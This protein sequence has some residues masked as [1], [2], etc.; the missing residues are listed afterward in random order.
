MTTALGSSRAAISKIAMLA[1]LA[2]TGIVSPAHAQTTATVSV[3]AGSSLNTLQPQSIGVNT[4]VWDGNLLDSAVPGLLS[5][6]GIG[7]MRFP[8][9]STSDTYNWQ[10]DSIV[11]GQG[12]Y[13]NPSNTFDAF[14]G[15]AKAAGA[16][17][18]ITVNYGSNTAGNGGGTPAAAAAWVQYANVTKGYG[19]Q[20]WEIGNEVYGNGE[21]GSTW[22]TDLH[23][24]HDP[25]TYGENVAQFAS[26]MKAVDSNIKVGVVLTAPGQWPDGVAP[27][28][29]TNVLAQCGSSIDFVVVHWYPQGPGSESDSYLLTTP[30]TISGMVSSLKSLIDEYC[31]ANASK[32]QILVTETNSVSYDPGK[33]ILSTV[34][35]LFIADNMMSWLENGVTNVDVWDLH[36]GSNS[37]NISSSL[38]GT[39]TYGDY[40]ILSN[41]SSGEPAADTP[42]ATYY[43]MQMLSRLGKSGDTMVSSTSSNSLL[44]VHAVKQANGDLALLLINKDPSNTDTAT[45]SVAGFKPG[46][47]ATEYVYGKSSSAILSNPLSVSGSTFTVSSLPYSLTTVVLTPSTGAAPAPNFSLSSSVSSLAMSQSGSGTSTITVTPSSGFTGSVSLSA[48]GLPSG[49]TALFSPSSTTGTSTLTLKA[50]STAAT[51]AATITVTGTSGS[52]THTATFS[53]QVNAS[54]TTSSPNFTLTSSLS[55]ATLSAGQTAT[56]TITLTPSGGFNGSVSLAQSGCPTGVIAWFN[57]NSITGSTT[58]NIEANSTAKAGTATIT[59]TGTSGSITHTATIAVTIGGS[60][61]TPAPS[62]TLSAGSSSASVTQGAS[63]TSSITVTPSNGFTSSV[64]LSASGLPSGVTA[65]FSPSST[66]GSSTLTLTASSSAAVGTSTVTITGTSESTSHTTT[67]SLQVNAAKT[68]T[69]NAP[70][71]TANFT[72]SSNVSRVSLSAGQTSTPTITVTPSGGFTGSVSLSQSGCPTGVIA[73]FNSNSTTGSTTFNIQVNSTAKPGTA[74]ITVTGT[75]GSIT[76][77]VTIPVTIG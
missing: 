71:G 50:S 28:W 54:A 17:P 6:A 56:P 12:G 59:V 14:M 2:M 26:A 65:S 25:T 38:F 49:V 20:Y 16:A 27:D 68:N 58:F 62:F 76:H 32:V 47:S 36:N 61:A 45:V 29:N 8:G 73:W 67:I 33:Q 48:S 70:T 3:N 5:S 44:A 13:A 10:T 9:G 39:A 24:A 19:V 43:G 34:N 37:G 69:T 55:S 15:V 18:I 35:A 23:S 11:P 75:S 51:G 66:T 1:C 41:A 53:L 72:L 31:G 52:L 46:S 77:T 64:A 74:S 42:F 21:Y 40:G 30:S 4:A 22:E 60:T 57:S 63:T 7:A